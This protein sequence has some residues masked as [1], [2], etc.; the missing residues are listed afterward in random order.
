MSEN[1]YG[2]MSTDNIE[3]AEDRLGGYSALDTDAY[4]ATIKALIAGKSKDGAHSIQILATINGSEYRETVYT[5]NKKGEPFYYPKTDGKPDTSKPK[6]FIP[7]YV[8][9]DDLVLMTTGAPLKEAVFEERVMKVYDADQGKEVNKNVPVLVAAMGKEVGLLINKTVEDK[10]K[11]EGDSYVPTGETREQ[12]SIAKVFSLD[13]EK[14]V[15][16]TKKEVPAE[17]VKAWL[18]K[19]KGNV[20]D[21]STKNAGGGARTGRPGSNTPPQSGQTER[22]SLFNK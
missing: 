4:Q 20:K 22:K 16:E 6:Q 21:N 12:N 9:I 3:E 11:K 19:W 14:T 17:F 18:D 13:T 15:S 5:T 8:T 7:G 1:I 2:G 10:T